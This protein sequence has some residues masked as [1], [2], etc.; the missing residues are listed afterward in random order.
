MDN[1]VVAFDMDRCHMELNYPYA[2][3]HIPVTK[4][5]KLFNLMC[6][7][8]WRNETAIK[9]TEEY[10]SLCI[11]E[12]ESDAKAAVKRYA[13]GYVDTKFKYHLTKAEKQRIEKENRR[14][15]NNAVRKKR[16]LTESRKCK[17]LLRKS[18]K[19]TKST[20]KRRIKLCIRTFLPKF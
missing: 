18:K 5:K 2:L 3:M 7:Q 17:S 6:C 9:T 20:N 16:T 12:T 8:A 19:N 15:Y 11:T 13:D 4:L 1:T 14:L 10:I